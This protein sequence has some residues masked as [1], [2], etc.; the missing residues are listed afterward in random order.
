M[1]QPHIFGMMPESR[2]ARDPAVTQTGPSAEAAGFFMA[3]PRNNRDAPYVPSPAKIEQAAEAIRAGWSESDHR[4]RAGWLA[5]P[6]TVQEYHDPPGGYGV[7]IWEAEAW[8]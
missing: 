2:I 4:K 7:G 3:R 5:G 6:V 1:T 8:A